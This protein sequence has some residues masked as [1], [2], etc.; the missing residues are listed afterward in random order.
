[1]NIKKPAV[2]YHPC[3]IKASSIFTPQPPPIPMYY[4]R[5]PVRLTFEDADWGTLTD[6]E[7]SESK[8]ELSS[9]TFV[10]TKPFLRLK[11]A[12]MPTCGL[13]G[14]GK[15]LANTLC[16]AVEENPC[17]E[18][19]NTR[20]HQHPAPGALIWTRSLNQVDQALL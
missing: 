4:A 17:E 5:N 13:H 8:Q 20:Q 9:R 12:E 14:V 18:E 2:S 15:P 7:E 1:M 6:D 11:S 16:A 3:P 10:P 19:S